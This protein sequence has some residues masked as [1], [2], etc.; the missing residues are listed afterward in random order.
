M[1]KIIEIHL[2][3]RET[4][5]KYLAGKEQNK[6][7]PL[8]VWSTKRHEQRQTHIHTHA[9]RATQSRHANIQLTL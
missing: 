5:A 2:A 4:T 7:I 3:T 1:S 9:Q 8:W 6:V